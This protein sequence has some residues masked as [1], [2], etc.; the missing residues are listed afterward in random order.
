MWKQVE[1]T[2][3][4]TGSDVWSPTAGKKIAV[5]SYEIGT[6]GTTAALVTLW[7]GLTADTTFTQGTDQ[8]LFRGVLTPTSSGTPGVVS[9][10]SSPVYCTTADMEL[11]L[12]TSAGITIYVTVFWLRVLMTLRMRRG[13]AAPP[14]PGGADPVYTFPTT[15]F[16]FPTFPDDGGVAAAVGVINVLDYGAVGTGIADDTNAIQAA[17]EAAF[18][19]STQACMKKT[20]YF[21]NAA[22]RRLPPDG[23]VGNTRGILQRRNALQAGALGT[24]W[25]GGMRLQGR[26]R[27]V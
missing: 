17:V 19:P 27:P 3:T 24:R 7:F 26:P 16:T 11:H 15:P 25:K 20:V 22:S 10:F 23:S 9:N 8:V 13:G 1:A 21:P 2:T 6:G 12:T 4:Q 14:V 5:T 18:D